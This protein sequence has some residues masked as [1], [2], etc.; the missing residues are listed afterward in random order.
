[1]I[2]NEQLII[3]YSTS[4]GKFEFKSKTV[5]WEE[6]FTLKKCI[7]S[8]ICIRVSQIN[9]TNWNIY[10]YTHICMHIYVHVYLYIIDLLYEIGSH[11]YRGWKVQTQENLRGPFDFKG[12]IRLMFHLK[13]SYVKTGKKKKKNV[14][15]TLFSI[16]SISRLKEAHPG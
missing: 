6:I 1:M 8:D 10:I 15:Q 4:S 2:Y 7:S 14:I 12:R 11:D 3:Y 9:K 16:Q 13:C 5:K